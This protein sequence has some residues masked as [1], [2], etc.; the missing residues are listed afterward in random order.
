IFDD[1]TTAFRW[2][3]FPFKAKSS[4]MKMLRPRVN[5]DADFKF[6]YYAMRGIRFTPSDHARHWISQYSKFRIPVPPMEVQREIVTILDAF[7]ELEVELEVELEAR[8]VQYAFF[9]ESLL[10]SP[11]GAHWMPLGEVGKVSMCKRVFKN[12]TSS[13]GEI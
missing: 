1:F 8:R 4:A 7:A 6:V 3:D 12:E 10:S 2:V 13:K 5:A 11:K 9:V